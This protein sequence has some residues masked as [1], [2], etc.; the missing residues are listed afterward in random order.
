MTGQKTGYTRAVQPLA[1]SATTTDSAGLA[2]GSI[3]IPTAD[4]GIP[5]FFARPEA[6][7]PH[8]VVLVVHE[9]F[10]L[11]EYIRDVCRRLAK[12]GYF[13]VAPDLYQRQG[14][15]SQID[16]IATIISDVVEKVPDGQVLADLDATVAWAASNAHA[17]TG[18]LGI[19]GFCWGGR[20]VWVYA[21]HHPGI[22][23]GV[24]WYGRLVGAGPGALGRIAQGRTYPIDVAGRL[25]GP[26]LG[27]HGDQDMAIPQATVEQMRAALAAA[28]DASEL[29]VYPGAQHGFHADYRP[30]YHADAAADG[31]QRLLDWFRH[32]GVQG[33]APVTSPEGPGGGPTRLRNST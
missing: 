15:V 14:D 16:D 2:T 25:N 20:F 30:Q 23:A 27:L 4:G 19:T 8:A 9:I 24:A 11:H 26:V 3:L 22:R 7:G 5:A 1:A 6:D 18:R 21:A 28:G 32:N 12:S 31:W 10:G 33:D 17:D 29:I 13:S